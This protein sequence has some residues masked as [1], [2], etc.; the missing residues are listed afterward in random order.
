[1]ISILLAT[2]NWPQA[3][4]LC[5]ESLATQTDHHFEIIIADDGSTESTKQII[6]AFQSTH[7]LSI[8]HLWQEDQGFRKTKILNQAI[9]AA[10]GDYLIFLDGD[11]LVQPDFVA[12]HRELAQKGFLVTGS[13][14][15]LN[16][17]L[18]Q[19]LLATSR[20]DFKLFISK[21]LEYRLNAG[22]NKYWPL[23]I[24]LGNGSW[25]DYKKFVWRR[26]K[27]CNM[28]CWKTDA[29][30]IDGF[31]ETMTGWGHEDADFV[32]RLQRHHIKRKSGSWS[33]E[34]LH[35]FH[36]IHDQSNAA[37][38]ARRVREKILAKAM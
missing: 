30:A 20:W 31:D 38:N 19:E 28:A 35:L 34:V 36:Q 25:R 5:L 11:C 7:S 22:I 21:L 12:R 23:K 24:K 1:M 29:Q 10:K 2:Y 13:R 32:F 27:G 37:E 8:T 14:V 17:K 3:L 18:T 4:K 6:D 9:E 15:L 33:T 26:I 16:E